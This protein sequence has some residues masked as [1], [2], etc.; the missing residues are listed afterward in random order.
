M[1]EP[2]TVIVFVRGIVII[3]NERLSLVDEGLFGNG[4]DY[5]LLF[6]A[7]QASMIKSI[8]SKTLETRQ[9]QR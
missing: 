4:V 6:G 1:P 3:V 5:L 9:R 7:M 2:V 8:S